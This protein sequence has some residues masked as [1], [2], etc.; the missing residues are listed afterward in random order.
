MS[1]DNLNTLAIADAL[2]AAAGMAADLL[3]KLDNANEQMRSAPLGVLPDGTPV[4]DMLEDL[5]DTKARLAASY[6]FFRTINHHVNSCN[7]STAFA[8][9]KAIRD[10]IAEAKKDP[11]P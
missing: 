7:S 9:I 6:S 4:E 11:T 3:E 8:A 10:L 5:K 1:A 2:R